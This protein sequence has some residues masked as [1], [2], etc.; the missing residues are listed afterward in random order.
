MSPVYLPS[1]IHSDLRNFTVFET[2]RGS[3]T[4]RV[5]I[6]LGWQELVNM[7]HLCNFFLDIK[8]ELVSL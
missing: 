6:Q 1:T 7:L 2:G 5:V 4:E 3:M 8:T